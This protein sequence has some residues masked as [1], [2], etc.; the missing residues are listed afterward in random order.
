MLLKRHYNVT[1]REGCAS[2]FLIQTVNT[3]AEVPFIIVGLIA[4]L[5][6]HILPAT[7]EIAMIAGV[8]MIV[9]FVVWLMVALHR[10][11][12]V[13]L[14]QRLQASRWGE[15]LSRGLDVLGDIEERLYTFVRHRP[16]KFAG[17][18]LLA[19]VNW[20]FGAGELFL[21]LAFLG[22][23]VGVM[24][25]WLMET[26]VVMVR[27]VTFF[28]PGHLGTQDGII[29]LMGQML[30]GSPEVG[31]AVALVR[32]ARELL[33]SGVGL[34]IGAMFGLRKAMAAP[35]ALT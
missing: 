16:G 31:L 12:L 4:A 29:T 9:N 8:V 3:M 25:A 32:R 28:V 35:E 5:H 13:S 27:N 22:H 6:R 11:W 33:W 19:F 24:D 23:P 30:T 18:V 14:Q 2:L 20:L 17:A 15:R 7:L 21:I 10:R 34:G 26:A 1:Y